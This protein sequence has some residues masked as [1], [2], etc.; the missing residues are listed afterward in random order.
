MSPPTLGWPHRFVPGSRLGA[1]PLLLLHGTG[2]NEDDLIPL[3]Q[4]LAQGAPLLSPRGPVLENG[5]PRFFRRFAEGVF[6]LEDLKLRARQLAEFIAAA[7]ETYGL[8]E[9]APVAVGFSNGA[10]IA[11]ALL[12]LHPGSL[13][14]ALLFRAMVPLVPDPL[15]V[16]RDVPVLLAAGRLDPIATP[17]QTEELAQLLSRSGAEVATHWSNAGHNLTREDLQAGERWLAATSAAP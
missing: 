4:A 17:A 5:M 10:N 2:G 9:V 1:P 8:G 11:A 12:L 14:A 6:D 16:L 7:R 15:P 13:S 3:G